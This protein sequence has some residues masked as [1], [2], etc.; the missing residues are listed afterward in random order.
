MSRIHSIVGGGAIASSSAPLE[1]MVVVLQR[2]ADAKTASISAGHS[3]NH[4]R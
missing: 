1:W 4:C 3:R 2:L